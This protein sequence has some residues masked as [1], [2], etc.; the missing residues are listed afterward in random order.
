MDYITRIFW[1]TSLVTL[2]RFTDGQLH[3][4]TSRSTKNVNNPT[5]NGQLHNSTSRSTKNVN[6]PTKRQIGLQL[7][8]PISRGR[9]VVQRPPP[10]LDTRSQSEENEVLEEEWTN[11]KILYNKTYPTPEIEFLRK[12]NFFTNRRSVTKFN[13]DYAFGLSNFVLRMNSY[14]DMLGGEFN[15][16]LNGFIGG[17]RKKETIDFRKSAFIHPVNARTPESID[18][19]ELG[20]VTPVKNQGLCAS[21]HAFSAAGA[22]EGQNF[23]KYGVLVE[24]SPQNLVDCPQEKKY[25]SFGCNGG[26]VDEN[27]KY[28]K[29]NPGINVD[30]TYVYE[31]ANGPCRFKP[32]SI[33]ANVTGYVDIPEGD[34]KALEAAVA[35]L[36][37]VSV[38]IDASQMTFQFYS[39][40][41]YY[42]EDCKNEAKSV[43][44]A[45]LV[46]GFGREPDGQ[47]YWLVK[48]SYGPEWGNGGYIKT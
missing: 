34:E 30:P 38:G 6:N 41:V 4:S 25:Q 47:K 14:A 1:L 37:P 15:N 27:F 42:D 44:H 39:Q 20:A 19:R 48:N 17:N 9:V 24:L 40:G 33:G 23:R 11:F 13:Q 22:V 7:V 43:N 45:V 31:A 12:Q 16:V 21:C 10:D 5:K 3:N 18:W 35:A 46:V 29:E 28:I 32:D 8:T 2:V 36:G 26:Y